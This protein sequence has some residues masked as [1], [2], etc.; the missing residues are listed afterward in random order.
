M[1]K[2]GVFHKFCKGSAAAGLAAMLA[3]LPLGGAV[4]EADVWD[5]I[6]GIYGTS[7]VYEMYV[8]QYLMMGDSPKNQQSHLVSA[9]KKYGADTNQQDCQLVDGVM[10]QLLH[11]GSYVLRSRSLPFR[12]AVVNDGSFNAGCTAMDSVAINKGLIV[13]LHG[14]RDELAG[15]LGHEMVHGLHQHLAHEL[16]HR[17][18]EEYGMNLINMGNRGNR[19]LFDIFRQYYDAKNVSLPA[20]YDADENG[21]YIMASAG[22]NPGGMA[23][24][25]AKMQEYTKNSGEFADFFNPS[26]HPDTDKRLEKTAKQLE[27]YGYR[28]V[29]VKN[30]KDIYLDNTLL[31]STLPMD[32]HTAEEMA[33]LVAGGLD[34]GFHDNR[35]A[36]AWWFKK[37]PDGTVDFLNNDPAYQTMKT[38]I[39][40]NKVENQLEALVTAAYTDDSRTG[41]RDMIYALEKKRIDNLKAE[42][43]AKMRV[44]ESTRE[45]M[46]GAA[47]AYLDLH[48]PA[49]A[50][51]Q[52]NRLFAANQADVYSYE[53]RGHA[54]IQ[55]HQPQKAIADLDTAIQNDPKYAW[56]Y[57]R[58]AE[59]YLALNN[60]TQALQDAEQ[61]IKYRPKLS[62]SYLI[63]GKIFDSEGNTASAL[64]VYRRVKQVNPKIKI[65]EKY[66]QLLDQGN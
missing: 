20:E 66:Q 41:N 30:G 42:A 43:A 44:D 39:H 53:I 61:A 62:L 32:N 22:F 1:E 63:Q 16:A 34:K 24:M 52:I 50:M 58:R 5:I 59:A 57:A 48:Q 10:N 45:E 37:K 21:F 55:L 51:T 4:A 23:A 3:L 6:G 12:W 9:M 11:K 25:M 8:D 33:Y 19:Q 38:A 60:K 36:T 40:Q 56:A 27:E 28:H 13:G 15:V 64:D 26:D 35:L 18:A 49:L 29:T 54:H 46:N 65:P 17:V 7:Q 2:K 31:L 14:D 47:D